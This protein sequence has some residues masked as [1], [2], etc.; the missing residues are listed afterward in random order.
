M[1]PQANH[2]EVTHG[3]MRISV[4]RDIFEGPEAIPIPEK[5][6][7]FSDLVRGR[8]PWI[9]ENSV[10]VLMRNARK[11]MLTVLEEESHGMC[12]ARLKE[13]KGDLDGAIAQMRRWAEKEP[14]N[15]DV[16]YYLGQLYFKAGRN[17]EGHKAMN[18]G[19]SLI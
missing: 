7:A 1:S 19:R 12:V 18:R 16:W 9:S 3:T 11:T 2:I 10:E 14:N 17:D 4:P 13:A 5:V 6:A 8:Y 15:C